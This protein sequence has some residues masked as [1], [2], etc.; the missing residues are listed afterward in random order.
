MLGLLSLLFFP[1][2]THSKP[3]PRQAPCSCRLQTFP[4]FPLDLLFAPDHTDP[5]ELRCG[6]SAEGLSS[7]HCPSPASLHLFYFIQMKPCLPMLNVS[8]L[9]A[10]TIIYFFCASLL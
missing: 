1:P 6:L 10:R 4:P 2:L 3:S 5:S 8:S 9:K 7:R